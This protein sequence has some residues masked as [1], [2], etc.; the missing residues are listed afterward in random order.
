MTATLDL[1]ANADDQQL[2]AQ[3]VAY[4]QRTLQNSAAPW[5][6]WRATA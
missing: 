6:T 4:Y 3:V 5:P 1:H 2:L